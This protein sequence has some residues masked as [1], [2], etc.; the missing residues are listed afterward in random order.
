[1]NTPHQT[2]AAVLVSTCEH[3]VS[4]RATTNKGDALAVALALR[5]VPVTEVRLLSAGPMTEAVARD[6]LALGA[7]RIDL[8]EGQ[9]GPADDA[10][11]MLVSAVAE[12]PLVLTGARSNGGTG[13]GLLPYALA[14]ALGRPVI[15]RVV[16]VQPQGQA[17][18]V[19][20]ALP[21]GARRQLLVSKPVVLVVSASAPVTLRHAHVFSQT[22]TLQRLS[23]AANTPAKPESPRLVPRVLQLQTLQARTEQSGHARMLQAIGSQ[24]SSGAGEVVQTGTPRQKAQLILN[25]LREHA[26]VNF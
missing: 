20:Q 4:G 2:A 21:K 25:H 15:D 19:E 26:L 23:M 14:A 10:L 18:L 3:P 5:I 16:S 11:A 13:S 8:L 12:T 6:Y 9:A 17:W 24:G 22:G 1:M 7:A